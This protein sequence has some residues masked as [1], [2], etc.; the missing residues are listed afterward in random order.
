[1]MEI[2]ILNILLKADVKIK[3][4]FNQGRTINK[5]PDINTQNYLK[6]SS[7]LETINDNYIKEQI[8]KIMENSF[9]DNEK[10]KEIIKLGNIDKHITNNDTEYL[11]KY[12][13]YLLPYNKNIQ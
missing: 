2:I 11:S 4:A 12:S 1:M 10:M 5:M 8:K 3:K 7:I 6:A 9:I 13:E